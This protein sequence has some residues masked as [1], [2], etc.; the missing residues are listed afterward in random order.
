VQKYSIIKKICLSFLDEF[1][2]VDYIIEPT[3][4]NYVVV[5]GRSVFYEENGDLT[6]TN[7]TIAIVSL[8][9]NDGSIKEIS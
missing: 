6:E 2:S 9:S 1:N 8:Y 7:N 3:L 5:K 4:N